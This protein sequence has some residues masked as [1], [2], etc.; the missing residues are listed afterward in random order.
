MAKNMRYDGKTITWTNGGS[1]VSAGDPVV[2]GGNGTALLCVALGDI[3]NGESGEL[4]TE[5]VWQLPKAS[6]AVI[7]QGETVIFD[8]SNGNFEDNQATP[9]TGDVS[10]ACVAW[11]AAGN[12]ATV[13]DVKINVSVGAIAA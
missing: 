2:V 11:S 1:A 10:G 9:A 12:G 7:G 13:V 5:G 3:A 8:V 4:A 6:A